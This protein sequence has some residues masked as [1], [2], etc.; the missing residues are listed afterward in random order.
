[1]KSLKM[2]YLECCSDS[3]LYL[4]LPLSK[5]LLI[6]QAGRMEEEV[7][8][9]EGEV[10]RESSKLRSEVLANSSVKESGNICDREGGTLTSESIVMLDFFIKLISQREKMMRKWVEFTRSLSSSFYTRTSMINLHC[11]FP[12]VLTS[13]LRLLTDSICL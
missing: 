4:L 1:M 2:D 5:S 13:P 10:G 11:S 3:D 12:L 8:E 6:L 9:W 7:V